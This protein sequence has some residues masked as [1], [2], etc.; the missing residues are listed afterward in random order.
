MLTAEELRLRNRK[1]RIITI[2][3]LAVVLVSVLGFFGARP[4]SNAIKAWQARRHAQKAFAYIDQEKW[5]EAHNEANAAYVLSPKEPQALRA[6]ARFLSRTRQIGALDFWKQLA[7]KTRL[8][9][10]DMR[11]E[12]MIAIIGSDTARADS[13]LR[14]LMGSHPEPADWLL[15]AQLA[16]QKNLPDEAKRYLAKII[17][18][19]RATESEQFRA[20]LL[21][22]ALAGDDQTLRTNALTRLKK[23]AKEKTAPALDALVVLAQNAFSIP[24]ES[25]DSPA[26]H[27][28]TD[29]ARALENHP[30]AKAQ[31]KL[32]ALD[33]LAHVDPARRDANIARAIADWK[34]A[35]PAAKANFRKHS[36]RSRSRKRCNRAIFFCGILMRWVG[37]VAGAN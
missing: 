6:V 14:T 17:A 29:L 30:L 24:A 26:A 15:A 11:D 13:A 5:T 27:E 20:T 18:D 34:N 8:T 25:R 23:I 16:M 12:L 32:L 10:Q 37:S 28:M 22:Y 2:A 3:V 21:Q 7:E 1:R 19:P 33:L 35:E 9:H 36:T 31:H 4:A